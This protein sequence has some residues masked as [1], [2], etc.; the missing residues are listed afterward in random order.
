VP[1]RWA[2]DTNVYIRALRNRHELA[3]LKRFRVRAQARL[4]VSAIVALELR[5]GAPT[6]AHVTA[7]DDL[8]ELYVRRDRVIVPSFDAYVQAGRI[9][10]TA[11]TKERF[12]LAEAPRSFIND[13]ILATSCRESDVVLVTDNTRDFT[14]IQRHLKGFRFASTFPS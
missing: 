14:M 8:L 9:I 13:V 6:A 3:D 12:P 7:V 5:A 1:D 10:A 11:A 4:L 2:L